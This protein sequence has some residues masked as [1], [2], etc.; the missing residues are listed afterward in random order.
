[1][2]LYFPG[3]CHFFG[4]RSPTS[5]ASAETGRAGRRW[6]ASPGAALARR[7]AH[8]LL[9]GR[10]RVADVVGELDYVPED[11]KNRIA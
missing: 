3:E 10:R 1:M 5:A 11:W 9:V 2:T 8:A 4:C 7:V 6:R